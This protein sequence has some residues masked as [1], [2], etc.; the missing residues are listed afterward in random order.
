MNRSLLLT[1]SCLLAACATKPHPKSNEGTVSVAAQTAVYAAMAASAYRKPN[2][3]YFPLASIGWQRVDL[4]GKP[5]LQPTEQYRLTGLAYDIFEHKDLNQSVIAFRGTD[6]LVDYALANGAVLFSPPYWQA[7]DV[8]CAYQD[9]HPNKKLIVTGHSLGG[10]LAMGASVH[11]G[12]DAYGFNP[13]PRIFDGVGDYHLPAKRVLIYA[14]G[15]TLEKI[16]KRWRKIFDVVKQE[17]I[18]AFKLDEAT[19]RSDCL[20]YHLIEQGSQTDNTLKTLLAEINKA[21][22]NLNNLDCHKQA[23]K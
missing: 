22:P 23:S 14:E 6:N 18:Y 19:H 17:D 8:V 15:E 10:G 9:A 12:V 11:L 4:D 20:A 7:N 21:N 3:I 5:T 2:R 1:F 13:S 16:R